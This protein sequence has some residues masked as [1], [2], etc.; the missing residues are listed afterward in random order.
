M[1]IQ[2]REGLCNNL[3]DRF[4]SAHQKVLFQISSLAQNR[5]EHPLY[6]RLSLTYDN[7]FSMLVDTRTLKTTG[8]ARS[9][10][11]LTLHRR[12]HLFLKYRSFH[13]T[14][15]LISFAI[16]Y[17]NL[18]ELFLMRYLILQPLV[19]ALFYLS[20]IS[21][22]T[23]STSHTDFSLLSGFHWSHRSLL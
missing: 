3:T 17:Q 13:S 5:R 1:Y 20:L 12:L 15:P 6:N 16:T 11:H 21:K 4:G 19:N 22:R 9:S 18:W 10:D 7:C 23:I 14:K 8:F 2:L